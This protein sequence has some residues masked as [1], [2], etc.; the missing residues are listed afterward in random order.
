MTT[1]ML[2]PNKRTTV[3]ILIEELGEAIKKTNYHFHSGYEIND[4]RKP[5]TIFMN[6]LK[7]QPSIMRSPY[8]IRIKNRDF[9]LELN[10]SRFVS[11]LKFTDVEYSNFDV[12]RDSISKLN[13]ACAALDYDT[14]MDQTNTVDKFFQTTRKIIQGINDFKF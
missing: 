1:S 4:M 3:D 14:L 9:T 2:D 5:E 11:N 12:M 7:K 6:F 13:E 10:S 8:Y